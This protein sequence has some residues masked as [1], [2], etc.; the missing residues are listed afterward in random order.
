MKGWQIFVH[1][2]RQ[3]FGNFGGA[4]RVS[5]VLYVVLNG[6]ALI[7][8]LK[9]TGFAG[10][11]DQL[12]LR[13]AFMTGSFPWWQF[14]VAVLVEAFGGLWI[15]V[16]WHRYVLLNE[17]PSLVPTLR[18]DRIWAYFR[19]GLWIAIML[20]PIGIVFVLLSNLAVRVFQP[21]P[22]TFGIFAVILM[23]I[24]L[25]VG[26]L[27][28][29]L[30]VA[31]PGAALAAQSSVGEAWRATTGEWG[32]FFG[33]AVITSVASLLFWP[34]ESFVAGNRIL[35]VIWQIG[36]GWVQL[37]IGASI[38]TTLY[39]HYIEKRPLI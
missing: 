1:S 32:T 25:P 11:L 29:R 36:F 10:L 27:L 17:M 37:L 16:G 38:L 33:L 18:L 2:L 35:A 3:V 6:I 24:Q 31:L 9:V 28:F 20:I 23:I 13:Q 22:S 8:L 19:R 12:A 14:G 5:A 21:G 39:G 4:L 15:A 26:A 7:L 30:S 34:V